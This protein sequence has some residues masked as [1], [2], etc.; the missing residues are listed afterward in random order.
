MSSKFHNF[1]S[2]PTEIRHQIWITAIP[3]PRLID[4][5]TVRGEIRFTNITNNLD[6]RKR[7]FK[8][9]YAS[10][11]PVPS[12]LH[13]CSE[14]RDIALK[15]Y[16]LIF[17]TN[18]RPCRSAISNIIPRGHAADSLPFENPAPIFVD[19]S[20][21]V[22]FLTA[23]H[24]KDRLDQYPSMPRRFSFSFAS[25]F[26]E[27]NVLAETVPQ[28][29]LEQI[30]YIAMNRMLFHGIARFKDLRCHVMGDRI[31]GLVFLE[32]LQE[33]EDVHE[34][35]TRLWFT[36]LQHFEKGMRSRVKFLS[37]E[38]ALREEMKVKGGERIWGTGD[39][40]EMLNLGGEEINAIES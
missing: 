27:N 6:R 31:K 30:Q 5:H 14:S 23:D 24:N 16:Q 32:N 39:Y 13:T 34:W 33:G 35:G 11:L 8:H 29:I 25:S 19:L 12:L 2:L 21:D 7:P 18:P 40:Q 22:F 36:V 1:T 28:H 38:D 37:G 17:D 20:R 4:L 9:C 15:F 3:L 10:K 26:F